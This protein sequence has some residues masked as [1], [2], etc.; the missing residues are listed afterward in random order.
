MK[1]N[2]VQDFEECYYSTQPHALCMMK[3]MR[4][5]EILHQCI[6]LDAFLKIAQCILVTSYIGVSTPDV[7]DLM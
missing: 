7:I 3:W 6:C 2:F 4:N 5:G 1:G